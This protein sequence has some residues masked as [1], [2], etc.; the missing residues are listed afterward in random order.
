MQREVNQLQVELR[1]ASVQKEAEMAK[2]NSL[3][4]DFI[5]IKSLNENLNLRHEEEHRELKALRK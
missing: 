4:D 2:Q 3:R 5:R 1:D